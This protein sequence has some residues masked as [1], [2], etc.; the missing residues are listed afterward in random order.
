MEGNVW[1]KHLSI[2]A[3]APPAGNRAHSSGMC[4]DWES[5]SWPFGSQAGAQPTESC[6]PRQHSG[7]FISSKKNAFFSAVVYH[8]SLTCIY[9]WLCGRQKGI[10]R[11]G[12]FGSNMLQ[13]AALISEISHFN[14][15]FSWWV[16]YYKICL[17][18]YQRFSAGVPQ[19][20]LNMQH[21]AI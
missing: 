8:L 10:G 4:P 14:V 13:T 19:V 5:N 17:V 11:E 21:L 6:Q 3:C 15:I 7:N 18:T 16:L 2:V 20:L 12:R 9:S 1:G